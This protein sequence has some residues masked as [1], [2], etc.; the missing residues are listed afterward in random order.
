MSTFPVCTCGHLPHPD[1][2]ADTVLA[3]VE[4][5]KDRFGREHFTLFW[6]DPARAGSVER[7]AVHPGGLVREVVMCGHR[8]QRFHAELAAYALRAEGRGQRVVIE[9]ESAS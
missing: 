8:A 3:V 1:V 2:P 7:I 9:R 5:S 6:S 4:G